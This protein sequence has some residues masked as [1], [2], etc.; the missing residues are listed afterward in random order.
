MFNRISLG[1]SSLHTNYISPIF[2]TIWDNK[3]KITLLALSILLT[4]NTLYNEPTSLLVEKNFR[5]LTVAIPITYT[6][7]LPF[8]GFA[9]IVTSTIPEE[10]LGFSPGQLFQLYCESLPKIWS[11]WFT[12]AKVNT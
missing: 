11:W 10:F 6:L 7:T 8:V 2:R 4:Y 3:G 12:H 9:C 1:L 5:L